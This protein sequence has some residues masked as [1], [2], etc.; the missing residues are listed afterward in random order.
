MKII[1]SSN[2]H[3]GKSF[4][5]YGLIGDKL[6]VG[7]KRTFSKIIDLALAEAAELVILAGDTF[8]NL[9]VS[10]KTLDFFLSEICRLNK[11][12]VVVLPGSR[13]FYQKGSFWDEW[14]I[15]TPAPNLY[16]LANPEKPSMAISELGTIVY[17]YP[18]VA[19][20]SSENLL[21]KIRRNDES[22]THIAVVYGNIVR[23]DPSLEWNYPLG[24]ED[25]FAAPFDY[26][27]LGGQTSCR[28]YSDIG[29]KAAYSGS[30][31]ILGPDQTDAGNVLFINLNNG[32]VNIEPRHLGEFIWKNA[33][34]HMEAVAN[35]EDLEMQIR[36]MAGPETLLKVTLK[37]LTLFE[38][39]LDL[40]KL[41]CDLENDCLNLEIIDCTN[42]LPENIS[43]VKVQEKTILGQYLKLMVDKLNKADD[44]SRGDYYESLK[45]GYKLLA[46]KGI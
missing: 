45:I 43:A 20:I 5:G 27:A 21:S 9:D 39:G 32:Q 22:A 34:I 46:G 8:D 14:K 44:D 11:I 30:P 7:I 1:Q 38:A 13:D 29:L 31:E 3:L 35:F 25:L 17:G 16:L 26:L 18:P 24:I 23:P 2:I 37:G 36:E 19:A 6:R 28:D 42:V 10:Q 4:E 15:T 41:Q 40:D 12:P 33:E